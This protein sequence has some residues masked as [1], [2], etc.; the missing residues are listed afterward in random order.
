MR[1]YKGR[2]RVQVS[3][4]HGSP[5]ALDDSKHYDVLINSDRSRGQSIKGSRP[6]SKHANIRNSVNHK[7]TQPD[8]KGFQIPYPGPVRR[9]KTSALV[10]QFYSPE[11]PL[12]SLFKAFK[13]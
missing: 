9:V 1:L 7:G 3:G 10:I 5:Y 12:N 11:W 6:F 13:K 8:L 2:T 4:F